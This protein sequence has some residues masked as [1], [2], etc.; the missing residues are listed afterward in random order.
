M[1][2]L[3]LSAMALCLAPLAMPQGTGQGPFGAIPGDWVREKDISRVHF[4]PPGGMGKVSVYESEWLPAAEMID[5]FARGYEL[6]GCTRHGEAL[7]ATSDAPEIFEHGAP[8]TVPLDMPGERVTSQIDMRCASPEQGPAQ[9]V[10]MGATGPGSRE[11][12]I[13]ME[14]PEIGAW[15]GMHDDLKSGMEG[16]AKGSI[17]LPRKW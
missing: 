8:D 11:L 10:F 2:A 9:I 5:Q 6:L 16:F 7:P 15:P 14:A 3:F 1:K 4:L 13:I 17:R 12:I